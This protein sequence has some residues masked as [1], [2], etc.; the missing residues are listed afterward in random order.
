MRLLPLLAWAL[1]PG[2]GAVTGPRTVRGFLG[3][4][5]SVTCTYQPGWEKFPKFWCIPSRKVFT[6]ANDIVITSESQ[7]EVLQGRFSIR[8]NR[9]HRAFTVTV[10]GLS[11]E[12]AGTFRC[13]V[14]TGLFASDMSAAVEVIVLS[15]SSILP[16]L[17]YVTTTTSDLILSVTG[18]TQ[19]ISQGEIL[20]STSNPSTPQLLNVV[21][22]IL[23]L[24][25]VVVL[26]LLAVAAGVLV[27]LSRK[28]KA[29]SMLHPALS[30]A[31]IEMD[32]TCR[33][34]PTGAEALNYADINHGTGAAESQYSNAEAFRHRETLPVEYTEVRKSAQLSEE[35]REVLYARVQKP[36]RQQEQIY[37][38]M[39]SA[40]QPS[41]E[42]YSTVW[43]K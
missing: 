19:T 17:T 1:L 18:H 23:T 28:K 12:D 10:D 38:N 36:M 9:T 2:C 34:S 30:G 3:G 35:E 5:L 16:S 20:Q 22:H 8:D 7:P 40:P 37:A 4:S 13:G 14:R 6:C 26:F 25:I 11:E 39:P 21:E 42:L 31:A 41:E 24:A 32:R 27:I 29:T 43:G 33:V 15:G